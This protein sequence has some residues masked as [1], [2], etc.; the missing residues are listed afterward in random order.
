MARQIYVARDASDKQAALAGLADNNRRMLTVSR[1]P[2]GKAGS[3]MLA[4]A[5]S[6]GETERNALVGTPDEICRGLAAVNKAGAHYV[7]LN[8][9]GGKDQLRAFAREIMP[10]FSPAQTQSPSAQT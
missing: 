3:H 2:D 9:L 4:Y 6:P 5:N 7:L 8:I 10:E 1:A